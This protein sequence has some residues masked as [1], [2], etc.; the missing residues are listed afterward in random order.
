MRSMKHFL[1]AVTGIP[2][3]ISGF[4][5]FNIFYHPMNEWHYNFFKCKK[6]KC[7]PCSYCK[8]DK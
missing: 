1:Y 5:P 3:H 4:I 6:C 8:E 2:I 7:S